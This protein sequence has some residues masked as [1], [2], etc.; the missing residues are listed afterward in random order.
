MPALKAL[1]IIAAALAG[2][3]ARECIPAVPHGTTWSIRSWGPGEHL[4]NQVAFVDYDTPEDQM[5][6]W[7]EDHLLVCYFR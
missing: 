5:R 6:E 7:A 4:V 1:A 2:A 3:T